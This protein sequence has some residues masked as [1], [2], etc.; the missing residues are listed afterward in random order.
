M[1]LRRGFKTQAELISVA[2]RA[3]IGLS[4][5]DPLDPHRLAEHLGIPVAMLEG[6]RP[7]APEAVDHLLGEG[8]RCFSAA[9]VFRGTRRM[10]VANPAHPPGRQANSLAHELAHVLLEHQPGPA[11]DTLGARVWPGE[12]EEEA[13]WLGGA[14]LAPREGILA[15]MIRCD[16]DVAAAAAH[17]GVS[18]ELMTWRYNQTGVA[19]QLGARDA[20]EAS[21]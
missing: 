13:D 7:R 17:F 19:R 1:P 4:P 8:V 2:V 18:T 5:A 21:P 9:T 15:V 20:K 16:R 12:H 10:I 3:E 14:L 6:L 11:I